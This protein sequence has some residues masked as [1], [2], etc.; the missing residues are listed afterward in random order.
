MAA[1]S[2]LIHSVTR[3][4]RLR[5]ALAIAVL[6]AA[7]LALLMAGQPTPA[8]AQSLSADTTL[9]SV[10]IDGTAV[11]GFVA[12]ESAAHHGVA[13][14]TSQVTVAGTA[15]DANASVDYGGTDA[16]V[17]TAGH[18]VDL[19]A[20]SNEVTITVTAE[21]ATSTQAWTIHIN[22]GVNTLRGW[23]ASEDFDTLI[24]AGNDDA[25]AIWS[26]G[27][28]MWV[29]DR[30]DRKIYA[31]NLS[32]K[33]RDASKD[34][35]T[36]DAAGN[37]DPEGIWSDSTTMWVTDLIDSKVYAYN[38]S[39]K[40]RDA[41][42]DFNTLEAA[43]NRYPTGIWSDGTT[44]WISDG[45]TYR[46]YTYHLSTK[47]KDA[48]K[49]LNTVDMI[50]R[51]PLDIWSDGATIWITVFNSNQIHAF[52]LST[53]MRDSSKSFTTPTGAG[54][55]NPYGIWSDGITMWV[56]DRT[57]EKLFSYVQRVL[58]DDTTLSAITVDGTTVAG[59]DQDTPLHRHAVD[60]DTT[61]VTVAATATDEYATLEII[62]PVDADG[63]TD[64]HQVEVGE[65][66][67][68]I[69]VRG[70]ADNRTDTQDYTLRIVRPST[71]YFD[72]KQT[73]DFDAL[74]INNPSPSAIWAN[75]TTMWVADLQHD[76]LFA[77][78][79][80]TKAREAANDIN[81]TN[82][83]VVSP[84]GAWS[85]GTT[86][87][88]SG[89]SVGRLYAFA[90]ATDTRDTAK[91]F[92]TLAA[93][94]NDNPE[95]IWSDGTTMWV[96][97][98]ADD[99]IYA[100]NLSTKA[101]DASRDINNLLD[102][103]VRSPTGIWSDGATMWV[104]DSNDATLY[105]FPLSDGER[106]AD[107]DFNTPGDAG[108]TN[109]YGIWSDGVTLW[110][111]DL[112][113]GKVY[114]YNLSRPGVLDLSFLSYE[115]SLT[116]DP[117]DEPDPIPGFDPSITSYTYEGDITPAFEI[118]DT[119]ENEDA[120]VSYNLPDFKTETEH[121]N[122]NLSE[123]NTTLV[124]TV[125]LEGNP[126]LKQYFIHFHFDDVPGDVHAPTFVELDPPGKPDVSTRGT[127]STPGDVDAYRPAI[128][129]LGPV[130][131]I[132]AR[133]DTVGDSEHTLAV[134]LLALG[135]DYRDYSGKRIT[136]EYLKY[137]SGAYSIGD[138]PFSG[139]DGWA[140][141][142]FEL[143]A[144]ESGNRN[145]RGFMLS[146]SSEVEGGTGT[147]E[148]LIRSH[149]DEQYP[150]DATGAGTVTPGTG[151][152]GK[153][154]YAF[155]KDWFKIT[156]LEPDGE[157]LVWARGGRVHH[158][159]RVYDSSGD[160]VD[161]HHTDRFVFRPETNGNYYIEVSGLLR[162]IRGD[163]R[164]YV[165]DLLTIT[166]TAAVG[167]TLSLDTSEV[168]DLDGLTSVTDLDG[169]EYRWI[170]VYD[171]GRTKRIK[172]GK[173]SG[174][175][176]TYT[177]TDDDV[178]HRI[179]ARI[180]Y[181]DDRSRTVH[182]KECRFSQVSDVVP[183]GISNQTGNQ[184]ATGAPT[185][186]G[187]TN[188]G[189]TVT[190]DVSNIADEDGLENVSYDYQWLADGVA[191]TDATS[192]TYTLAAD[193]FGKAVSVRVSFTDGADNQ[194][195]LTSEGVY[196][197]MTLTERTD[198][199]PAA[200]QPTISGT[201]RVGESLTASTDLI[202]DED[203]TENVAY[204]YQW[205]ADDVNIADANT[206]HY[207][208]TTSEEGDAIKVVVS[209]TDDAD[210][211]E[212]L[213]SAATVAV[214][215]KVPEAPTSLTGSMNPDGSITITWT[216]PENDTVTG[217]QI[218]RRR[219]RENEPQLLTHVQNTGNADTGYTDTDTAQN[220][221]YVYRVKAINASGTGPQS[222]HTEVERYLNSTAT[223]APTISGTAQVG[224]TL[225][226]GTT[227]IADADGL[228]NVSYAYRWLADGAEIA[229][230][231]GA[232]YSLTDSEEGK[233][234]RVK[235]SFTDDAENEETLTSAATAAVEAAATTEPP[236]APT[237]L[238][239]AVNS[240]GS[241]TISWT[242]P[243]DDSVTGYQILRRRPRESEPTLLAYEDDTGSTSTSFTDTTTALDTLYVYRVKA[244]NSAG[245]GPQSNYVNIDKS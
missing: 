104:A 144:A 67:T 6:I 79:L 88:V 65:G 21:D 83:H 105:A 190:A 185:I 55:T 17:D 102:H 149:D 39:T 172:A 219:P 118:H 5:G 243:D 53:K 52:D 13:H 137:I 20:G 71:A 213:T 32:T 168:H 222:N 191:I 161:G 162:E 135:Y 89:F 92:T 199:T 43:D 241:I 136:R 98:S 95:G 11:P 163:Y 158:A 51:S 227:G 112:T 152:A 182:D 3:R 33:A 90:L 240:D 237:G 85:D 69:T 167:S 173:Q 24:A 155:D 220:T 203:G 50:R 200:G 181:Y 201:P 142:L 187:A 40:A 78:N 49:D 114:S 73:E 108:N 208:L 116:V 8:E 70:T 97:D 129:K 210:N 141:I 151:V 244:R 86:I 119:P 77:Y 150:N 218:L 80:S 68:N 75:D 174:G 99:K 183:L 212:T 58:G 165:H 157:Y 28:T 164:L 171:D 36:L 25:Q 18:Q 134:P 54:N 205:L 121:L 204:T 41:S 4:N 179:K 166:G 230:A 34:L 60:A 147:Y 101:R 38:L 225:T 184:L 211:D 131:E 87:C 9:S 195:S 224:E 193:D 15:E 140:R 139:A 232:S 180:C 207:T 27:T 198:N 23:K 169:W 217:Y 76:K 57:D 130:Y 63:A 226:A 113:D 120:N 231:T 124:I 115:G 45:I 107:R 160:P 138:R 106:D 194:E 238:T 229:G 133:G 91:D 82:S 153:L 74:D 35:D 44:V 66:I 22:R 117:E 228:E 126:T 145:I 242:A 202:T 170:R 96:A 188:V 215:S 1:A 214:A 81:E 156:G 178:D 59:S 14:D 84:R 132:I 234:L 31:Y 109:P 176:D 100:Y 62:L 72:W 186:T 197:T 209:F 46:I 125:T 123:G 245:L 177:V 42:K 16:D 196:P 148:V 94:D 61:Q 128:F 64:G 48:S 239:G 10:S 7:A 146:V 30:D 216:A 12:T 223:G 192:N 93:A 236:A 111:A 189:D 143:K 47:A 122:L 110:V 26:D 235:V 29:L 19:S 206:A 56:S 233:A 221:T 103:G 37:D 2:L 154:N 175:Y 159:V 127:I